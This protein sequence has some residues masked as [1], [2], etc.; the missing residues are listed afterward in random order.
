MESFKGL[1]FLA[2]KGFKLLKEVRSIFLNYLLLLVIASGIFH[3]LISKFIT[4]FF[5]FKCFKEKMESTEV[6]AFL[7]P[8][9]CTG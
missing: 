7:K 6:N 3:Y 2:G 4:F 8:S 9:K 5:T 1:F